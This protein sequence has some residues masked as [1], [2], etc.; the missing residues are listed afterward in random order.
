MLPPAI[1]YPVLLFLRED[2]LSP[3]LSMKGVDTDFRNTKH[4]DLLDSNN[5]VFLASLLHTPSPPL[6]LS[7]FNS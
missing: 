3:R 7:P 6:Y 5:R 1:F 4:P 2:P